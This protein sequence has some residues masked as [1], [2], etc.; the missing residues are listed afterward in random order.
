MAR[1][2]IV[3]ANA[4]G[5]W[6]DD[7]T[8]ARRQVEG[9]RIDYLVMDYLAEVT[10]AIL[11]KQRQRRPEAGFA[12]DFIAQL[13]DVLPACIDRGVRIVTNAGG[14]NPMACRAAVEDLAREQGVSDQLKV[15]V[16]MGDDIYDELDSILSAGEVLA[17][18]DTGA[19][20]SDIRDRVL[21][22]NVYLGAAPVAEALRMGAN[23]VIAGRITDTALTL[24]PMMHEFEWRE[25]DWDRLAAGIVAGHIIE[26][27]AQSTGG[28]FTDWRKVPN[29]DNLGYPLIEAY[30]DGTFV[31]TKH[32][33]TGGLVSVHTVGEQLLYEMGAPG[34]VAPDCVAH[35]DSIVLEQEGPDRVRVSAVRG[36]PA[37]EKLKV[38]VSFSHGYRIF[39]RIM[40]SGPDCLEKAGKVADIF[41]KMAGGE[42][43]YEET[44]THFIGWNG[45][46]PPLSQHE[47]SEVL[48]QVAAR[49]SDREKLDTRFGPF[50]VAGILGSVPGITPAA[51]Q[52]RPRASDVLGYWPALISR[53]RVKVRVC[54]GETEEQ[55][56][57]A[58]PLQRAGKAFTPARVEPVVPSSGRQVTVP[59]SRLCLARS[60]D[61]G[62]TANVGVIGRTPGVYGWMLEHL[63]ADFVKNHFRELCGGSVERY[64]LPNLL[65][66]NFVLREA[67]GGGGTL[68]IRFDAQGKTYGQ[69]LLAARVTVD[70]QI[71]EEVDA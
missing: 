42:D 8:V 15:A 56:S 25:D 32:A 6:G 13:R 41:W 29:F 37:P 34:Y 68:S 71:V 60:G 69:Y 66:L 55:V 40:V 67:L 27:G 35:F 45:S 20:L 39:G 19:P 46:H 61:K 51:D 62:N 48:L 64:E 49:D 31:V 44:A 21:S 43:M 26:C 9:G 22:A 24:G 63:T 17:N 3:V 65:S 10:M 1:D 28:N 23:V 59:L 16:I 70:R 5:F 58:R 4:G 53:D 12:G 36:D 38:S 33:G 52:G 47:P 11:Q 54:V 50:V 57:S 18:M 30:P 2:K 14:V 7:P